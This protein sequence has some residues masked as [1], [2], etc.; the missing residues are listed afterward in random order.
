MTPGKERVYTDPT[1]GNLIIR[2]GGDADDPDR[3]YLIAGVE[4]VQVLREDLP[5]LV[6][7]L[8][9]AVGEEVI[10]LHRTATPIPGYRAVEVPGGKV[11]IDGNRVAL[12]TGHHTSFWRPNE[13]RIVAAVLATAAD[14]AESEP[15]TT[16]V[17]RWQEI[18]G[19]IVEQ[20]GGPALAHAVAREIAYI[21]QEIR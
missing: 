5:S 20:S 7:H 3:I 15:D 21:L 14:R 16:E 8:Y 11:H 4:M 18:I 10:V 13:A 19:P 9:R 6:Q 2:P 17:E 12:T 1:G